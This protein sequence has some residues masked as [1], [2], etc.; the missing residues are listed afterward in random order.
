MYKLP[1]ILALSALIAGCASVPITSPSA[2]IIK[3]SS[4]DR[5]LFENVQHDVKA[6]GQSVIY[7]S[8]KRVDTKHLHGGHIDYQLVDNS[9]GLIIE[10]GTVAYSE[11][12][13]DVL[14]T[15]P[16]LQRKMK[17]RSSYFEIPLKHRWQPDQYQLHL[18][19]DS[20]S[21]SVHT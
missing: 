16:S 15:N 1:V 5:V 11:G 7:G 21:H 4:G 12:I 3:K 14:P 19:W 17:K 20:G 8:L 18:N 2:I 10:S 6:N 13:Q 9:N